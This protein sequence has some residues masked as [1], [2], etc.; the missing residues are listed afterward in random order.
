MGVV[1]MA[2]LNDELYAVANNLTG[3]VSRL[4]QLG[5]TWEVLPSLPTSRK[6]FSV[7]VLDNQLFVIGGQDAAG[8]ELNIVEKFDRETNSWSASR[9]MIE[10]RSDFSTA[11]LNG[12]IYAVGG[13]NNSTES[14]FS[15]AIIVGKE[16][17]V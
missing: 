16:Y 11:A 7:T 5:G 10:S 8:N 3:S 17:L 13:A 14:K 9:V 4:K 15:N 6:N 12:Y 1:E 2:V